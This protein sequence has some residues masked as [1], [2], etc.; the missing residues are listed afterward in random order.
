[1]R[2]KSGLIGIL[3]C[4]FLSCTF[5]SAEDMSSNTSTTNKEVAA[6][7]IFYFSVSW[8]VEAKNSKEAM[9][10]ND[11][12]TAKAKAI[13][14]K[15][16]LKALEGIRSYASLDKRGF[17]KNSKNTLFLSGGLSGGYEVTDDKVVN[18]IIS[19]FDSIDYISLTFDQG[20]AY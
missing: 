18:N 3:A 4:V 6:K 2:Y 5:A 16:N 8:S 19:D 9:Q 7:K 10:K 1:M 15:Y 11:V 20:Y 13:L 14:Q 17:D 12:N